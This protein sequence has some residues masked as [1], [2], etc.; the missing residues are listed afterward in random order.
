MSENRQ[1][2]DDESLRPLEKVAAKLETSVRNLARWRKRGDDL[3]PFYKLGNRIF[4]KVGEIN[5]CIERRRVEPP[6]PPAPSTAAPR[7]SRPSRK[8]K[9]KH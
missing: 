9:G 6:A 5:A 2:D 3:P 7:P 8:A 4:C 1:P